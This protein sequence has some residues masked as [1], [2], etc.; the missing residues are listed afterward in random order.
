MVS[1]G[2]HFDD[3]T[4][5]VRSC[6]TL[7]LMKSYIFYCISRCTL[8]TLYKKVLTYL[9]YKVISLGDILILTLLGNKVHAEPPTTMANM[10]DHRSL[11]V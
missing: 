1:R 8:M 4:F 2:A 5:L 11:S 10:R 3:A 9:C 7:F 6:L